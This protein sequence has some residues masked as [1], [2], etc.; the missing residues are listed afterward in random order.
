MSTGYGYFI[1]AFN[2]AQSLLDISNIVASG[3]KFKDL[4]PL[5]KYLNLSS[6]DISKITSVTTNTIKRWKS[7][8]KI[9]TLAAAYFFRIDRT[10]EKGIELFGNKDELKKWLNSSNISLGTRPRELLLDPIGIELIDEALDALH[11][12]NVI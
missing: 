5:I 8:T 11:F 6:N 7:T 3:L 4:K 12:G 1:S 9:G 10:L 2:K